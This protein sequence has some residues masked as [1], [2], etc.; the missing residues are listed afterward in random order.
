MAAG[1]VPRI[2]VE[3]GPF[4]ETAELAALRAVRTDVGAV[5]SFLGLCRDDG[6][7]LRALEIE[8]Y[9]DMA[10]AEIRRIA[11]EAAARWA[12]TA[13]TVLHRFGVVVPGEP[14]V[15]V[16]AASVHRREAFAAVEFV[17]D[18]LKT[19]APFWK[20]EHPADGSP[21]RWIDAKAT[22]RARKERWEES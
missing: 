15:L 6:G 2:V 10:E 7:S 4:D 9:P 1:F 12:L 19:D 21:P 8:A 11:D 3:H 17:M 22:D 18:F 20:K 16:A 14:I 13:L 5:V